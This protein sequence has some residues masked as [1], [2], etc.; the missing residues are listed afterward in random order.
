MNFGSKLMGV[1]GELLVNLVI[2]S[3]AAGIGTWFYLGRVIRWGLL[4]DFLENEI[5][6][7]C[8]I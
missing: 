4:K 8:H 3:A 7:R 1:T 6:E 2:W 5:V